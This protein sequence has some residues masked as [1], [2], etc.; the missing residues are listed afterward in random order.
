MSILLGVQKISKSFDHRKLFSDL[1]FVV[2][3]GEKIGLIG[4]NGAGK[5]T[6]LNIISGKIDCDDGELSG[7]KGLRIAF[8]EQKPS[9]QSGATVQSTLLEASEHPEEW[10]SHT[11]VGEYLSK[12]SLDGTHGIG[13]QT[14][15]AN[16]SGGW[17]KRVAL[18]REL[19]REPDLFLLDEPTNH[20]DVA[21]ILWLENLLMKASFATLTIT[22][23][24]LFLQRVANRIMELNKRYSNG[25]LSIKGNY[26]R[27]LQTKDQIERD[28]KTQ[29]QRLEN[30]H[31]RELEWLQR[32]ARARST[33]QKA[34]IQRA[35]TMERDLQDLLY[36]NQSK[37]VR[38]LFQTGEK[39]PKKL[40]EA[41]GVSKSYDGQ[42]IVSDCNLLI[43]PGN[44]IG[45]MGPNGCG[46]STLIRLLLGLEEPD[47]GYV[48]RN[49][50]LTPA[51]FEQNRE[52]LN[53]QINL[54]ET[55]C[56]T[57]DHVNY[58]GQM[59]HIRSYL[60]QFLFQKAQMSMPVGSLSGGEQSRL[61]MARLML[62]DA[63]LI[64]LD[65]PTN[66]LDL[67]T[68]QVL[69]DCL[70]QFAGAVILVT[71]DRYFLD[72]VA[73]QVLGFTPRG[74]GADGELVPFADFLQWEA[75]YF[76]QEKLKRG[77]D[78]EISSPKETRKKKKTK[79]SYIDQ[80]EYDSMEA[81]IL[82]DEEKLTRLKEEVGH[83]EV[84]SD[85][86]KLLELT[87]II[88]DLEAEIHTK[89]ARWTK[90]EQKKQDVE[91]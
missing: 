74:L 26:S 78:P 83:P 14:P 16:L 46:K 90:L 73:N 40:L 3:S 29:E 81:S 84:V 67:E 87:N 12:L 41:K 66:D 71:H 5:T 37:S 17:Q 89:Y 31:R 44:R 72:N 49:K 27:Y 36:R 23:D 15:I 48:T 55:L 21:S 85:A 28:Q 51:Y 20:L 50:H 68:L 69:E 8:L 63:N 54:M 79:L 52:S 4:P 43:N 58:R 7:Q 39:R 56:P 30:L 75:W 42:P 19:I 59:I 25:L 62:Q 11:Q 6:L 61:L 65:E 80:R 2:E 33:K 70:T 60:D 53:P 38:L 24:R 47:T 9:F 10:E 22:H 57:G 34:R 13:P 77:T 82:S 1:T 76:E 18:A 35:V 64:V 91:S 88:N 86:G 32:G 45:L